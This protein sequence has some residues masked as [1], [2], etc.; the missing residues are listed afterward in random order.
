MH[1]QVNFE[2]FDVIFRNDMLVDLAEQ[3]LG[4]TTSQVFAHLLDLMQKR[5][6]RCHKDPF[7]DEMHKIDDELTIR[8][9][10]L[11]QSLKPSLDLSQGITKVKSE[12][13]VDKR[14]LEK[15]LAKRDRIQE[16]EENALAK[17]AAPADPSVI[18]SGHAA[19]QTQRME[20]N[21]Q[22]PDDEEE[23]ETMDDEDDDDVNEDGNIPE[24]IEDAN[25]DG[26]DDPFLGKSSH[27]RSKVTFS[28]D[29]PQTEEDHAA[30][31]EQ[32]N[33]HLTLLAADEY[34]FARPYGEEQWTV[35]FAPLV[36]RL[37]DTEIDSIIM[38]TFGKGAHRLV[39]MMRKEGK[40]DEK[41]LP[42]TS[43]L[44]P[45]E[46][47][48]QLAKMQMAG[49][50]DVQGIPRDAAH[51]VNRSI[52]LWYFDHERVAAIVLKKLYK[53]MARHISRLDVERAR[54][55]E[56][57]SLAERTDIQDGT[58]KLSEEHLEALNKFRDIEDRLMG[59]MKQCDMLVGIF[60]DF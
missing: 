3:R 10:D 19:P 22:D 2:K 53:L 38:H 11:Y 25:M 60:R 43:L 16:E 33:Y 34:C 45:K 17:A 49:Y 36:E 57:L 18:I 46:I 40:L 37:R 41:L 52:F 51:S 24:V 8:I 56:I 4:P 30:R 6:A 32:L 12:K 44:S 42:N 23:D 28:K 15:L 58:E 14:F 47:R 59:K 20:Q 39:R 7:I 48:T 1:I 35:D 54:H 31:L 5:I 9:E 27:K 21:E 26:A 55:D 50:V 13:L 29:I